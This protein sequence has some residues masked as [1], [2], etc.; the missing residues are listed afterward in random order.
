MSQ[1]LR[2]LTASINRTQCMVIF[3]NQIRMKILVRF[4]MA[5]RK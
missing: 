3:I 4:L 5:T 1:A 2:K